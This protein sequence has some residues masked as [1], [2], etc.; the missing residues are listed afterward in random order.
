MLFE[1]GVDL[2]RLLFELGVL[3]PAAL[4]EPPVKNVDR[5]SGLASIYRGRSED[6]ID[7]GHD[8]VLRE[9]ARRKNLRWVVGVKIR[10]D[11]ALDGLHGR[12]KIGLLDVGGGER[13]VDH[14]GSSVARN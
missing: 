2:R 8:G 10:G 5:V 6:P 1:E 13:V 11:P 12:I 7:A 4:E 9:P 3:D 14:G